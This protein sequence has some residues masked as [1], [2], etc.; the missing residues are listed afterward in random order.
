MKIEAGKF[1]RTRAGRK[2]RIYAI[3]CGVDWPIHGAVQHDGFWKVCKWDNNGKR[4][5]CIGGE[6]SLISEWIEPLD[7]DPSC[8]PAWAEWIAMDLNGTWW[9]YCDDPRP[10]GAV[11]YVGGEDNCSIIPEEYAPKNFTGDWKDS[12]HK[13]SDL[14]NHES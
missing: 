11:C 2:A 13:V 3:D 14:K 5:N 1:Y 8:L 9:W 4:P 7:F 10:R 6:L 12:V